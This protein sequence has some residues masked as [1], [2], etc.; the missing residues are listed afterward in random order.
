MNKNT[1]PNGPKITSL[2]ELLDKHHGII[3][4]K[5]RTKFEIQSTLFMIGAVIKEERRL[6][7]MSKAQLAKKTGIKKSVI[8]RIEN[9]Q[10]DIKLSTIFKL[11]EFGLGRKVRLDIK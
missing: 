6:K 1:K 11:I 8:S 4:T 7:S 5:K 10:G 2:D 3:G 9:E